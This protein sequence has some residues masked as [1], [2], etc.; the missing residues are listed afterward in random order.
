MRSSAG[1]SL[2]LFVASGWRGRRHLPHF[3]FFKIINQTCD[4]QICSTSSESLLLRQR[5][6]CRLNRCCL[7]GKCSGPTS[8][9][10]YASTC[11]RFSCY[12]DLSQSY[13][14]LFTSYLM[15]HGVICTNYW[16][17]FVRHGA[18]INTGSHRAHYGS[19]VDFRTNVSSQAI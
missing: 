14:T 1:K 3:I 2:S 8:A 6:T 4:W 10:D 15:F 16:S 18:P 9:F 5:Q 7:G 11:P 12:F 17:L 13:H 19:H